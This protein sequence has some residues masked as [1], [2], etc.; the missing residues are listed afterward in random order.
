MT[1]ALKL[2]S[3]AGLALSIVPAVLV[4]K[5]MIGWPAYQ[6][7]MIVGM[8]LWFGAAV[9]WIKPHRDGE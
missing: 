9:L 3:Y 8:L 2:V 6:V 1:S 4:F 7:L 5:G